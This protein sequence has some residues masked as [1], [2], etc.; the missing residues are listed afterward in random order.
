MAKVARKGM[1]AYNA[2][3]LF[4]RAVAANKG[5]AV[6]KDEDLKLATVAALGLPADDEQQGDARGL[7]D[8]CWGDLRAP[9]LAGLK[10]DDNGYT[11]DNSCAVLKAHKEVRGEVVALCAP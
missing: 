3:P 2:V 4:K 9:I 8:A 10:A 1:N 11:K 5:P 6:C 7:A